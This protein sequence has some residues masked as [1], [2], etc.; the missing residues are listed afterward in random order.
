MADVAKALT[1]HS[2]HWP[3]IMDEF[4]KLIKIRIYKKL[5]G[6]CVREGIICEKALQI[7]NDL[8]RKAPSAECEIRFTFK[9][10]RSW[11]LEL[12]HYCVAKNGEA[13]SSN[14][15]AVEDILSNFVT[16]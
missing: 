13:T 4:E 14:K 1:V 8:Q 6:D 3:Q 5:T 16:I 15:K 12:R 10:S 11:F 2:K 7:C 9:A